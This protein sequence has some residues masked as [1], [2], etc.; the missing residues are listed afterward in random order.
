MFDDYTG[1]LKRLL[2]SDN[3]TDNSTSSINETTSSPTLN[4]TQ[5]N[6][7]D[8]DTTASPITNTN[9]SRNIGQMTCTFQ[10]YFPTALGEPNFL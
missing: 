7:T 10:E 4:S 9:S 2:S 6:S 5:G 8:I 3:S 1:V